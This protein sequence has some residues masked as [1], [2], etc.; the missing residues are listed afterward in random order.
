MGSSRSPLRIWLVEWFAAGNLGF[1]ALD[2]YLAHSVNEF[3]HPAEWVPVVFSAL[4]PLLLLPGLL[5]RV[6]RGGFAGAVGLGVGGASVLV[7]VAGMLFHLESAFFARQTLH[8]LVYSAPFVAPLAYAGVGLLLLLNRMEA[9]DSAS[10]GRWV[11]VLGLG[12]FVG[13]L[14]LSLLDHAQNGFFEWAEW[15][16]VVAA[17][18]GVGFLFIAILR[19]RPAFLKLCLAVMVVEVLVG[20]AGF[21][22]HFQSDLA[23]SAESVRDRFIYGAPLFA[24]LLFA[25][26]A[27]LSALG[28]WH[29]VERA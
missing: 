8:S 10:W 17:A 27:I 13:N 23:R 3:R 15:I 6:H 19:P 11:L 18:Y 14:A 16:P 5:R 2:V 24:P 4:A 26:L 9:D 20:V 1:L 22:L 25:N 29:E 28:L 21:L 12:G 7:G